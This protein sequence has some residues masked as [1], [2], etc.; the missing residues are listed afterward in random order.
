MSRRTAAR[1]QGSK[2][3]DGGS[4]LLEVVTGV[5]LLAVLSTT[6]LGLHT[7][8]LDGAERASERG[9]ATVLARDELEIRAA[10]DAHD[11][12]SDD[13]GLDTHAHTLSITPTATTIEDDHCAMAVSVLHGVR[14]AT[15]REGV[16]LAGAWIPRS[17]TSLPSD[18][19]TPGGL[20]ILGRPEA[21]GGPIGPVAD[22]I[23]IEPEG[24]G[25]RLLPL[26]GSCAGL[27]AL[28]PGHHRLTPAEHNGTVLVDAIQRPALLAPLSLHVLDRPVRR[29]WDVVPA[30][31]LRVEVDTDGAR[32]P[33]A[34]SSGALW[35]S[36]RGDDLRDMRALGADRPVR[37]GRVVTVVTA[38]LNP[39]ASGS[40]AVHELQAG[41]AAEVTVPLAIITVGGLTDWPDETLQ[42]VRTSGCADGSGLRPILQWDGDLRDGMRIALPHGEWEGRLQTADG[43]R[44]T[45]PVRFPASGLD[46]TVIL[47]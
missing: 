17:A 25:T 29:I 20:L 40:T 19:A 1:A 47:P 6:M 9:R 35:W 21:P 46:T 7:A 5:G 11:G 33:D 16:V 27:G 30:A 42:L 24:V 28:G 23:M 13:T 36:V 26:D 45:R 37:P 41:G 38:C 22:A 32:P 18:V 34:V 3:D 15:A 12:V 8:A 10:V 43:L 39:E 2:G 4:V 14:I 31:L 44:I